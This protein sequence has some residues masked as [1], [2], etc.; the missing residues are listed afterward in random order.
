LH[1]L[2]GWQFIRFLRRGKASSLCCLRDP[3]AEENMKMQVFGERD[4]I[5]IQFDTIFA[6][7]CHRSRDDFRCRIRRI[8]ELFATEIDSEILE[9]VNQL[10]LLIEDLRSFS[11]RVRTEIYRRA[12][13]ELLSAWRQIMRGDSLRARYY[14]KLA[15]ECCH[16]MD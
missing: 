1:G 9:A 16:E 4:A 14:L 10:D 15:E 6:A 11:A 13:I 2:S 7:L 12:R 8:D 3:T 5:D